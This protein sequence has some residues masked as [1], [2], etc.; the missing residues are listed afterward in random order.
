M[1]LYLRKTG[2]QNIKGLGMLWN[3]LDNSLVYVI[4]QTR[5]AQFQFFLYRLKWSEKLFIIIKM[6]YWA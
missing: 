3:K 4:V 1:Y 5:E 6:G 2:S